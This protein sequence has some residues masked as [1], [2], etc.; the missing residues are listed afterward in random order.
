MRFRNLS[1]NTCEKVSYFLKVQSECQGMFCYCLFFKIVFLNSLSVGSLLSM[2][3]DGF[4]KDWLGMFCINWLLQFSMFIIEMWCKVVF[5]ERTGLLSC[6][7]LLLGFF[8]FLHFLNI[9]S[10]LLGFINSVSI[11]SNILVSQSDFTRFLFS[12]SNLII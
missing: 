6:F 9:L 7:W 4:C 2:I 12:F 1:L 10:S 3:G 8:A 11:L 5:G